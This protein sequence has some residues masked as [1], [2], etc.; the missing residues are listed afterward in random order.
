M[1]QGAGDG[2]G[3]GGGVVAGGVRGDSLRYFVTD[4]VTLSW[5]HTEHFANMYFKHAMLLSIYTM[6]SPAGPVQLGMW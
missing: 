5:I 4:R 2:V 6:A 1:Q 3:A